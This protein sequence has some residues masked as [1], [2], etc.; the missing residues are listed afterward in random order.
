[1]KHLKIIAFNLFLTQIIFAQFVPLRTILEVEGPINSNI[2]LGTGI[3]GL[4]DVNG[5][6]KADFAVSA[7]NAK[8][9]YIYYGG[10][11]IIDGV[12]DDSIPGGGII[13]TGD[14]NGDGVLDLVIKLNSDSSWVNY[15]LF[16]LQG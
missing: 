11:G 10:K 8:K 13:E 16:I 7:W 3:K 12:A 5:D 4:G 15:L 2:A 9:T 14:L 6:G 1:M